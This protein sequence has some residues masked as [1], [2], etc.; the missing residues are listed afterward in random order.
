[1]G[2]ANFKALL[3]DDPRFWKAFLNTVYYVLGVVP[4]G[5]FVNTGCTIAGTVVTDATAAYADFIYAY[6]QF[7][8][9][10]CDQTL[11]GTLA[12][13]TLPPGVYCFTAAATLT[14]VLKLNAQGDPNAVWIFKIGAGTDG[15]GATGALTTTSFTVDMIGGGQPCNVYWWVAQAAT[16]NT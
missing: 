12:G 14:G 16:L 11:T 7:P 3:L 5:S 4:I 10:S 13:V 1:M 6:S 15:N 8:S 2:I 9:I